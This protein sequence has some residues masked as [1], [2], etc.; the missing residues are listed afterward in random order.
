MKNTLWVLVPVGAVTVTWT[1]PV[2]GGVLAVIC[3]SLTRMKLVPLGPNLTLVAP[4][5]PEPVMVTLVPP[6]ERLGRG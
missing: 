3:V 2:P 5:K 1:V 6:L 4:V